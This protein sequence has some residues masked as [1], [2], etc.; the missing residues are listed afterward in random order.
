MSHKRPRHLS[1]KLRAAVPW[2]WAAPLLES[3]LQ[4]RELLK[5]ITKKISDRYA[6]SQ[7]CW[8]RNEAWRKD[9]G[10]GMVQPKRLGAKDFTLGVSKETTGLWH[11]KLGSTV[12]CYMRRPGLRWSG[13]GKEHRW[14]EAGGDTADELMSGVFIYLITCPPSQEAKP[15]FM[16]L[17]SAHQQP[18]SGSVSLRGWRHMTR[19]GTPLV[20]VV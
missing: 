14:S 8:M 19:S 15:Q 10:G 18:S 3:R 11:Q 20:P 7:N 6:V 9:W 1:T 4:R 16:F 13:E 17:T 2:V 5:Y 12:T